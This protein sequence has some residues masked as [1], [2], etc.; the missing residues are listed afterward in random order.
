VPFTISD[1]RRQPQFFDI[2]AD[3]IWQAWWRPNGFPREHIVTGLTAN[4]ADTPIPSRWSPTR[5]N[6]SSARPR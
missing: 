2:V 4:M 3:R 1:L 5:A 6:G